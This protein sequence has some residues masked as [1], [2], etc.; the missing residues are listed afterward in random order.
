MAAVA[1]PIHSVRIV[2]FDHDPDGGL[3]EVITNQ[4][5]VLAGQGTLDGPSQ[6]LPGVYALP[7]SDFHDVITGTAIGAVY[8]DVHAE[9]DRAFAIVEL[10]ERDNTR[11]DES[12]GEHITRN[13]RNAVEVYRLTHSLGP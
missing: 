10:L 3:S 1:S 6:T 7:A 13:S 8:T 5:R 11:V 4:G 9:Y 2:Q 12:R